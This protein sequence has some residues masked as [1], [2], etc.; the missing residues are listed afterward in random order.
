[1]CTT[2]NEAST[3]TKTAIKPECETKR[4]PLDPR[5]PN[6]KIMISQNLIAEEETK[7]LLFLD[8]NNDVFTWKTSDLMGVSRSIIEHKLQV[9][10]SAKPRQQKLYKMSNEKIMASKVEVQRLLDT[11]FICEV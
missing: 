9:S 11:G 6:K 1:M 8:K 2:K 4:V 5:V 7:L 3:D 10:L